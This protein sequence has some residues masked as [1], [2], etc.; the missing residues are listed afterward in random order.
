MPHRATPARHHTL[1]CGLASLRMWVATQRNVAAS[2]KLTA[3]RPS[4]QI[5]ETPNQSRIQSAIRLIKMLHEEIVGRRKRLPHVPSTFIY[6]R[7]HQRT[8]LWLLPDQ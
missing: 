2:S 3:Q 4:T 8:H 7:F 5:V 6:W 1:Q